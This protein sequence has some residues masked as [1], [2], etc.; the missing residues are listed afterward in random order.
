VHINASLYNEEFLQI[1][2]NNQQKVSQILMIVMLS[3][4]NA[5]HPPTHPLLLI[6]RVEFVDKLI[7]V[8]GRLHD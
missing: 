3:E 6:N 7:E 1:C 2:Q 4:E 8:V 5:P